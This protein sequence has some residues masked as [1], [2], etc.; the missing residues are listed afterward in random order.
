MQS[1]VISGH[2]RS[3]EAII[4]QPTSFTRLLTPVG[5]P[6]LG[7]VRA[8]SSLALALSLAL[9]LAWALALALALARRLRHRLVM[10][11]VGAKHAA[12]RVL[13]ESLA[14]PPNGRLVRP[15]LKHEPLRR[16]RG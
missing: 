7:H 15:V 12:D 5:A 4:E 16:G 10:G 2:Q 13:V 3:S 6:A 1:E 8:A 14:K 9:S 11:A